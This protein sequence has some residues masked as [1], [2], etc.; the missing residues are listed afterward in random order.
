MQRE[1]NVS[2]ELDDVGKLILE[3]QMYSILEHFK[4]SNT[5]HVLFEI[6]TEFYSEHEYDFTNTT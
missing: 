3:I 6:T 2:C 4:S 1:C 5:M